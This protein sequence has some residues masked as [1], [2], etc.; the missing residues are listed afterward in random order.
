VTWLAAW[1][2]MAVLWLGL[3]VF[4]LYHQRSLARTF[5]LAALTSWMVLINAAEYCR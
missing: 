3:V 5:V 4:D 1:L 2:I